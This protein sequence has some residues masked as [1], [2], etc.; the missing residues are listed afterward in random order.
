VDGDPGNVFVGRTCG[1][2]FIDHDLLASLYSGLDCLLADT[3]QG[4]TIAFQVD[5][6]PYVPLHDFGNFDSA[7]QPLEG[8]YLTRIG[9]TNLLSES[10]F[11][12]R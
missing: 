5:S 12:P 6:E 4:N 8:E 10:F 2:S 7:F 11:E 3:Y 9:S 1:T